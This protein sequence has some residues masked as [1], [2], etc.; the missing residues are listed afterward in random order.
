[1][2]L[3]TMHQ[4]DHVKLLLPWKVICVYLFSIPCI[5]LSEIFVLILPLQVSPSILP[6]AVIVPYILPSEVLLPILPFRIIILGY[7]RK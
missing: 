7:F 2:Q 4:I 1:M 3:F 6:L 5:L